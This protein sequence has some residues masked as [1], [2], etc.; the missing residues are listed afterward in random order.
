MCLV[1]EDASWFPD[2]PTAAVPWPSGM[3]YGQKKTCTGCPWVTSMPIWDFPTTQ[4]VCGGSGP[5]QASLVLWKVAV[6]PSVFIE[7]LGKITLQSTQQPVQALR[8]VGACISE[9]FCRCPDSLCKVIKSQEY[10]MCVKAFR[11]YTVQIEMF[12]TAH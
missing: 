10:K 11:H 9:I 4:A 5:T 6:W 7:S 1:K 2:G 8:A 3:K 12:S